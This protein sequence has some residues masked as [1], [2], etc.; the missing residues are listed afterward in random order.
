MPTVLRPADHPHDR[1]ADRIN[2]ERIMS[3]F[4]KLEERL[5]VASELIED[6]DLKAAFTDLAARLEVL[7]HDTSILIF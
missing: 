3:L 6:E 5:V 2:P 7:H 1:T 4:N